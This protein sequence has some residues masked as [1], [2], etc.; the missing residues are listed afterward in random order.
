MDSPE[1]AAKRQGQ[2]ELSPEQML[3]RI[4]TDAGHWH[5]LAR[6]LP[7]LQVSVDAANCML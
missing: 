4:Q 1:E 6:Y 2:T 7:L 3:G 5:E